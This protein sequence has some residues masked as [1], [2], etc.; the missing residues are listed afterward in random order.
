MGLRHAETPPM[1]DTDEEHRQ[2]IALFR[3]GV[4][5]ELVQWPAGTKGLYERIEA[6]AA[7]EYSIPASTRTRIAAETIRHWLKAYRKGGFEAL[8]PKP[9]ADRG[10]VRRLPAAVAEALLATKEANPA[11]SVQLVIREARRRPEVP[12][13]LPLPPATVHR[14]LARH[15]LMDKT[16][17]EAGDSDRRRFAFAQAGELW[18]SD[19]M[20]GPA[21]VVG[22]RVKRKTYL[23]A[24]L[25]DATRVIPHAAF[26]LAENTRAFLPVLK[27]AIEKRG[28]PQRLYV[29]NG[30]NYRSRH[31]ALV[32]AKLGVALIHARPYRPQGKGKIERWFQSVRGQLLTRL[33]AEDTASLQALNRRL[34]VW[35]EGEYHHTPHR[36]LDG[37]TP[38]EQWARTA[39]AVRFPEPGLDLADLFLFETERKVQKDRTVSLNGVVYEVDAALVGE[40]VTLRFDP[41]APPERPIQVCH[42]GKRIELARPVQ[43][44]ANCFVKRDRP[45]WTLQADSPPPQPPPSALRLRELPD[46]DGDDGE[47]C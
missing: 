14:L 36:G 45:S 10:R 29:D 7:R 46:G 12:E 40:K 3:Y 5:A 26:A 6:K 47:G 4:I 30:A 13:D 39:E 15:G 41:G 21:V 35:I 1:T 28:L 42:A 34:A 20:H 25:D 24:F 17:G 9:R 11:L 16:K 33:A 31:L 32:C 43:T 38:L 22:E 27:L 44:Y 37:V 23:L 18:M 8:L 2:S 19:V